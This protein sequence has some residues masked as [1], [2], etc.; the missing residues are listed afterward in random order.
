MRAPL[1]ILAAILASCGAPG[2]DID[3]GP[4]QFIAIAGDFRDF[5]D[6]ERIE[7]DATAAP[8]GMTGEA[9]AVYVNR[10]APEGAARFEPGTIVV[11]TIE[12]GD[13]TTWTIHA[14]AK[15]GGDYNLRGALGW[16]FFELRIEPDGTP[17]VLWRG[18]GP[19]AGHGYGRD[20][21]DGGVLELVCNDC[22]AA[23]WRTDGV[24]TPAL[25]PR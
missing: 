8:A 22:H 11:K 4:T 16:E 18:E 10:R 9:A 24:L 17:I 20:L 5:R 21:P 6:W 2:A 13:P 12:V 3:A 23:A 1:A 14:M 25:A 15:R 19:S 7:I